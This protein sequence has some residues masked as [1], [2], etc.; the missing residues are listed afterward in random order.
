M[1]NVIIGTAGHI[2]HGKTCLIKALT[3]IDT[4]RLKEE[5]QRGITIELGFAD[6]PNDMDLDIGIIDVPGHE[7]FV[8]HMLAGIGGIDIVLL[9]VAADEGF[10]PQTKEHFEILKMLKIKK[11]IVVM[12]KADLADEEW[13]EVVKEDIKDNVAGTFLEGAPIMEVSS[14]TGQGIEELKKQILE[15]AAQ[16]GSRREDRRLLRLPIDRVFTIDGFG[17]VITGTLMEGSVGTGD[18]V[19]LYPSQKKAKVRNIQVHGNTVTEARAGQRTAINLAGIKKE[20]LNRGDVAAYPGLLENTRMIDVRIDMF[21]RTKRILKSGSRLHFYYGSAEALCK[22]VLLDQ[23]AIGEGESCYAQLRFEEEIAVKRGDRFILRFYSP[24]E[25]IGG[26]KILDAAAKKKKR[27]SE[28]AIASLKIQDEGKDQDVLAQIF[29]EES[30]RLGDLAEVIRKLGKTKE[31]A[32]ELVDALLEEKTI[33]KISEN[34]LLHKTY[35]SDVQSKAKALLEN[36]HRENPVS[37]G[38]PKEEFRGKLGRLLRT[39]DQKKLELLINDLLQGQAVKEE[40]GTMSLR[41]FQVTYTEEQKKMADRFGAIYEKAGLEPPLTQEV[42]AGEKDPRLAGQ[43]LGSMHNRGVL[44][45]LN[46]QYYMD[47]AALKSAIDVL[48]NTIDRQGKITLAQYRDLIGTSRKYAVM[49]LEY[50]DEN[51]ITK[52]TG[53]CRVL[54]RQED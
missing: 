9:I 29:L 12:T 10:M 49:I 54:Y 1:K 8:K 48:I 21:D 37:S 34:L 16:C 26:G 47:A 40:A 22:A 5:K 43:I 32:E 7:K 11:G 24:L 33:K 27:F 53:D 39:E 52:M 35:L 44:G 50:A 30:F 31:E 42:A 23:E 38:M 20:E 4:D 46:Y 36:Y 13:R 45:R 28:E 51:K 41:D 6:L 3:Q 25:T 14:Y 19:M 17:T 18:E 2:D 15:M